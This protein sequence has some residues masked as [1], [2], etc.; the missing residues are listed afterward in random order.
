EFLVKNAEHNGEQIRFLTFL[1][2]TDD[3]KKL[4]V[5]KSM[6]DDLF[7]FKNL[8]AMGTMISGIAHELNNP[9]SGISMSSQLAENSLKY[10]INSLK[11]SE[12]LPGII[13]NECLDSITY[14]LSELEHV[15]LNTARAAK[16]VGGLL[17]YSKKEKLELELCNLKNILDETIKITSYQPV[18][19]DKPIQYNCSDDIRFNCDRLKM[20]QVL[21]NIIKNAVEATKDDCL[22]KID[23]N[24]DE[25]F[26]TIS[27]KDNGCGISTTDLGQLFTPFFTTKGPKGGT[28]LGLSISYRIIERHGGKIAV[29]SEVGKGSEFIITIPKNLK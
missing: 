16:L 25:S 2:K 4:D 5:I 20:Q 26:V 3:I 23:C 8:A 19:N 13:F 21:Y 17:N 15:K 12:N 10:L 11:K 9:I 28:G 1:D 18:F 24:S 7:Q 27:I 14:S 29:H 6:Q 22:V